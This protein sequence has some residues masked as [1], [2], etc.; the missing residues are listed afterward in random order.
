L[1]SRSSGSITLDGDGDDD[2]EY[3]GTLIIIALLTPPPLLKVPLLSND[4]ASQPAMR[5]G[6]L[7]AKLTLPPTNNHH[8]NV[9]WKQQ[10]DLEEQGESSHPGLKTESTRTIQSAPLKV[11]S[12]F[13]HSRV[14]LPQG[15]CC[16]DLEFGCSED[17]SSC[18]CAERVKNVAS[19][20]GDVGPAIICC[21]LLCNA[22]SLLNC[23]T[24]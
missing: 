10:E 13:S 8:N 21:Q 15:C 3:M 22:E 1:A 7:S 24:Y 9:N 14:S 17:S 19:F 2:D 4:T 18:C 16:N 20:E 23:E 12:T 5:T 11:T 6:A